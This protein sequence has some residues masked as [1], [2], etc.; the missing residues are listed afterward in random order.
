MDIAMLEALGRRI[1]TLRQAR[2]L[3]LSAL[4]VKA[5]VAKSNLSNLEQGRGNPTLDTLW[6]L[7]KQLKVPFGV[8]IATEVGMASSVIDNGMYITLLGQGSAAH[9][10]DAYLMRVEAGA[11]RLAEPHTCGSEEHIM[12]LK[13]EV[14]VGHHDATR[15]LGPG[16]TTRFA[17]DHVHIYRALDED[18]A[19]LVT[20]IYPPV[21]QDHPA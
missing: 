6:R 17:A 4:A 20:I 1:T 15:Q 13:G 18:V 14:E 21:T 11:S 2:E 5:G 19:M 12:V 8:L 7:A 3:S 10:I 16:E 9:P